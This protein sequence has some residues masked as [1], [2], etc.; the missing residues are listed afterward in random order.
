MAA[1]ENIDATK[2]TDLEITHKLVEW[3]NKFHKL[4]EEYRESTNMTKEEFKTKFNALDSE[5]EMYFNEA[6]SRQIN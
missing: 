1:K 4:S 5:Y 6:K 3:H 2:L